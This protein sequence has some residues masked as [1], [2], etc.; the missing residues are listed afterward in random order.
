M[1]TN[2]TARKMKP[3]VIEASQHEYCDPAEDVVL[4]K[5]YPDDVNTGMA[6]GVERHAL[7]AIFFLGLAVV[8]PVSIGFLTVSGTL[9][10]IGRGLNISSAAQL[11]WVTSGYAVGSCVSFPLAGSISDI[12]GRRWVIISG[13]VIGI[14]GA[15]VGATATNVNTVI[16]SGT[17]LGFA[18]GI[19]FTIYA[20]VPEICPNRY[21]GLGLAW[22]EACILFPWG[23]L[24]VLLG[25]EIAATIGWRWIYIIAC[26][27][28]VIGVV[29]TAAFYFPPTRQHFD[30]RSKL[31]RFRQLDFLGLGL[32]VSGV[33]TLLIG[34]SWAGTTGHPWKSTSVI[35]PIVLGGV[36]LISAFAY[37]LTRG[38]KNHV[39]FPADLFS[40]TRKFTTALVAIFVAGMI[41][42]SMAALL[43]QAS[44][45]LFSDN[46]IELGLIQLPNGIGQTVGAVVGPMIL[47][48][49]KRPKYHIL[50]ALF[51]QTL[52]VGL[53][54]WALPKHKAA[55][56]AFQFFGQ[57]CFS[58]LSV[59][60]I[61]NA[62]LHVK[63]A[64][65]GIAT[66][67]I[68]TFRSFGGSVGNAIFNTIRSLVLT[69]H[70][71][72]EVV[73]AAAQHGFDAR[74][75]KNV[76]L[77]LTAVAK[78]VVGI[79]YAFKNVP[80][81]NAAVELASIQAFRHAQSTAF[82]TVFLSTIPFG[83]IAIVVAFFI[84]DASRLMNNHVAVKLR[85]R[86]GMV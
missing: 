30:E 3:E 54:A 50:V 24:A 8:C 21:R 28:G 65:L 66:G 56:M 81:A 86:R 25:K 9:L 83:V 17:V 27:Y 53:Y 7:I 61:M 64:E 41:F 51:V 71:A 67:V 59:C 33:T 72:P 82:R 73:K 2:S 31:T 12:F 38:E 6:A 37:D 11:Q 75:P 36:L 43:P 62:G 23:T 44:L 63:H 58:W 16:A 5:S 76:G 18:T 20:A 14:A 57:G 22:I 32:F 4:D 40:M 77:L 47:H 10:D 26:I 42:Y 13:Q 55:W 74:N 70:L 84:E 78:A 34:L 1:V 60:C 80:G 48:K 79:P 46:H 35:C 39:L 68:C 45:Y 15:I 85:N 19:V 29:G 52:G 49:T 69:K